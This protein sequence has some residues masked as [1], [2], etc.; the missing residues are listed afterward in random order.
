M[1]KLSIFMS[2]CIIILTL[3]PLTASASVFDITDRN[4]FDHYFYGDDSGAVK[5]LSSGDFKYSSYEGKYAMIEDYTGRD[6]NVTIPETLDSLSVIAIGRNAFIR[7]TFLKSVTI[8]DSVLYI[9]DDAFLLCTHLSQVN[10]GN[11]LKVIG[12]GAFSYCTSLEKLDTPDSLLSIC[13]VAF[14]GCSKLSEVNL[15]NSVKEIGSMAFSYCRDLTK[16]NIPSSVTELYGGV[17]H[18]CSSLESISL[19]DSVTRIGDIVFSHCKNLESVRMPSKLREIG[20]GAFVSCRSLEKLAVP[21]TV[22]KIAPDAFGYCKSSL[23]LSVVK[24]SY[25]DSYA[26]ENKMAIEYADTNETVE[27]G[28]SAMYDLL[29]F[30]LTAVNEIYYAVGEKS[31]FVFEFLYSFVL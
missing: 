3:L 20:T 10:F 9:A 27:S 1:K 11:G 16:I 2:V 5:N 13:N 26:I 4:D 30:V 22:E 24:D 21:E 18:A 15:G 19:P 8:P 6:K 28:K 29:G 31:G 25:A 23:A 12:G 14:E 17:F 7:D